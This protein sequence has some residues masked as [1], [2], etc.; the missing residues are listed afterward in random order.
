MTL[1]GTDFFETFGQRLSVS[2]GANAHGYFWE[3]CEHHCGK[4]GQ[5]YI[6]GVNQIHGVC[7]CV[8]V[9]VC[10][11]DSAGGGFL[12]SRQLV[13]HASLLAFEASIS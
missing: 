2:P 6:N 3:S 9:C 11:C 4:W 10:V 12:K 5:L 1:L 13:R 8:C 7:A